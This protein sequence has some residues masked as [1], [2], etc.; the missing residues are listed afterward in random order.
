MMAGRS[1]VK[2]SAN[3]G[4]DEHGQKAFSERVNKNTPH[5]AS[6]VKGICQ[7][8]VIAI[9]RSFDHFQ[10]YQSCHQPTAFPKF[11]LKSG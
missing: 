5:F 11:H 7:R 1:S 6:I 2:V 4:W 8:E 3:A 10:R 9:V